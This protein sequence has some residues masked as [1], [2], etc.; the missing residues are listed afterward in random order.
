MSACIG[1]RR[2]PRAQLLCVV[3]VLEGNHSDL[4]EAPVTTPP[5]AMDNET[6]KGCSS[7]YPEEASPIKKATRPTVTRPRSS[8]T[9]LVRTSSASDAIP[10]KTVSP[11][12]FQRTTSIPTRSSMPRWADGPELTEEDSDSGL[13]IDMSGLGLISFNKSVSSS[14]FTRVSSTHNSFLHPSAPP[15]SRTVLVWPG[16]RDWSLH[17]RESF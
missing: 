10:T 9:L 13:G 2:A 4:E 11:R 1:C 16:K 15:V 7:S 14:Q 6:L 12:E 5:Q 3:S 8:S 17:G